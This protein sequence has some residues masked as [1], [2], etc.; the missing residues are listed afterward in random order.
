MSLAE[1]LLFISS[2]HLGYLQP[3]QRSQLWC[4]RVSFVEQVRVN[5]AEKNEAEETKEE[6]EGGGEEEGEG[7]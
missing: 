2:L 3:T 4:E 6:G 5:I 1:A 7:K